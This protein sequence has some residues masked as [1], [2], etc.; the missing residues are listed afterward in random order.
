MMHENSAKI[1]GRDTAVDFA[2]ALCALFVIVIHSCYNG[3][4]QNA[5]GS[6]EWLSTLFWGSVTRGA[7]PIFLMCS[8]AILLKPEKELSMKKLF[9]KMLPRLLVALMFWALVY[10]LYYLVQGDFTASDLFY[11]VKRVLLF[12]HEFHL[13]YIHIILLGY[14]LLPVMRAF[15]SIGKRRVLEY[16]LLLWF[17]LGIIYPTIG[18][19]WPLNMVYGVPKQWMLNGTYGLLGYMLMGYYLKAYP[20]R[21]KWVYPLLFL[22]GLGAVFFGTWKLSAAKGSLD[23]TCFNGVSLWV[24]IEAVG[25]FGTICSGRWADKAGGSGFAQ[26]LSKASFCI[27]LAHPIILYEQR[28][29]GLDLDIAPCLVSIPLLSAMN[30]AICTGLYFII[31][32]IPLAKKWIV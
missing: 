6:F 23:E 1:T 3:Y 27:Y 24:C 32:K 9:G 13:Y 18:G 12:D 11:H 20:L 5:T 28:K 26:Y 14:A 8:G 22:L 19:S 17:L 16:A 10:K 4:Y 29:L 25:L 15:V 7:V 21:R 31:S 2:K 30:M